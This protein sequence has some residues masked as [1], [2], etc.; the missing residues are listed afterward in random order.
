MVTLATCSPIAARQGQMTRCRVSSAV[1]PP[2]EKGSLGNRTTHS[3]L[4]EWKA[5]P[6]SHGRYLA[7]VHWTQT[8]SWDHFSPESL[9]GPVLEIDREVTLPQGDGGGVAV[10]WAEARQ[11]G[12]TPAQQNLFPK[13]F[14][15]VQ[16]MLHSFIALHAHFNSMPNSRPENGP[17]NPT[18]SLPAREGGVFQGIS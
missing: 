13:L 16:W 18:G 3:A 12:E 4:G 11:G 17:P 6:E 15:T 8:F 10:R 5:G 1:T 9:P 7:V 14:W 2:P